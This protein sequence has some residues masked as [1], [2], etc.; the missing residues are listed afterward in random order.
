MRALHEVK[1]KR[2][3]VAVIEVYVEDPTDAEEVIEAIQ[4]DALELNWEADE[5]EEIELVLDDE[6]CT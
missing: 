5:N 6:D 3:Q 4:A 1:V 2:T